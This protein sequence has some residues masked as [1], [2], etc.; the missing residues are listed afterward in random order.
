MS[1]IPRWLPCGVEVNK[2]YRPG[3]VVECCRTICPDKPNNAVDICYAHHT[4]L[5][6]RE[7]LDAGIPLPLRGDAAWF[8]IKNIYL[9]RKHKRKEERHGT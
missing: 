4:A 1:Y 2:N 7:V 9:E 8:E 5:L 6:K 3:A